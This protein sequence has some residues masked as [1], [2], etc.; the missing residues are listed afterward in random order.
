MNPD[1]EQRLAAGRACL[2]AALQ[3]Y[4]P[5]GFSITWCCD[6]DHI[7]VYKKHGK[8]CQHPGKAPMHPWKKRQGERPTAAQIE[9]HWRNYPIG[10]VGCVLGQ[11]SALV[12]VDVDGEPGEAALQEWSQGDLPPTWEFRSSAAGRG[13]LYQWPEDQPCHTV[14]KASP[15]G[16][17]TELRLMGNGSQ[18]VLPPS[19][20]ASGSLYAWVPGHS[21]DE[22]PLAPAPA[23]L[24]AR[25][26]EESRPAAPP[27]GEAAALTQAYDAP[28][29]AYAAE[30]LGWVPNPGAD[31]DTW[32]NIGMALHST[33][34]AWAFALW[35]TWSQQY[36]EKYDA[37]DQAKVWNSF[38]LEGPAGKAPI[39]FGTLVHLARANGYQ[40]R[41][42]DTPG[43]PGGS[44]GKP[45]IRLD[46]DLSRWTDEGQTALCAL[47]KANGAPILYQR[48][49]RPVLIAAGVKPPRWLRRP[50]DAPTIL[51]A[52]EAALYELASR[53]AHWHKWDKGKKEWQAVLPPRLFVPTVLGRPFSPFP[54]LE[55]I[56]HSPTLRPDGSLLDTPGYDAATG[57]YFD[58]NGTTFPP[59]SDD[60]DIFDAQCAL[61]TLKDVLCGF[62]WA[63][64][65]DC[66]AAL[67][68]IL[69]GVCRYTIMGNVPLFGISA[70]TRASGKGLL[71]DVIALIGTGRRAPLWSQAEDDAEERKRLLALG[72]DGDPLVCI[73]NVT[74]PLGSAPLDL[75]LTSTTFK[76][77]VLGT[78][79]SKEVP[80]YALFLA[81]GN[82]LQYVGDL[83]RRVVPIL[84][85]PAME[86]PEERT[87]FRYPDLLTHVAKVRPQLVHA[88]LTIVKAYYVAGC[89]TQALSAYGSF[90]PWSDLI[91]SAL[92]WAGEGDPCEGRKTLVAQDLG[93]EALA[94]LLEAW[95][96]CYPP[97][98]HVTLKRLARDIV[99]YKDKSLPIP[100]PNTWDDLE[101]AVL[102]FD[103]GSSRHRAVNTRTLGHALKRV[104]G[105]IIA[106][107][108]FVRAGDYQ[109]ALEW[110]VEVMKETGG[111]P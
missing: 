53:A 75:A 78:Q 64:D 6:P 17:H 5:Q 16:A 45:V 59:L 51:E 39:T 110:K 96:A 60:P 66:L 32:R 12:R 74:R 98:D 3:V 100:N 70:T 57:L 77:R 54:A 35:D 37:D 80:L 42:G 8:E 22:L 40:S 20:H 111:Q 19:R 83:A 10:N 15:D 73:D 106:R 44:S 103:Q 46:I 104:Q 85:D 25:M 90:Q 11:V 23:W 67:A 2:E 69:T 13:L 28:T 7:G 108:R 48:A 34:T 68:A 84:L 18:T 97:G 26:T 62:L 109:H 76:D 71:A 65:Y 1:H 93:H 55:G 58:T 29:H 86:K 30:L 88:A 89:P 38:S 27:R 107:K 63:H 61:N 9:Q 95:H 91:R 105:R 50:P 24:V 49:R 94:G 92:V 33:G 79:T 102:E 52:S 21:P 31:R 14:I 81:T 72:M 41:N 87:G 101:Q 99:V 47:T 43:P 56:I 36:P 4:L 82:N